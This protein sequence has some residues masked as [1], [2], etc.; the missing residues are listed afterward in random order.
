MTTILMTLHTIKKKLN[1]HDELRCLILNA[2]GY[3]CGDGGFLNQGPFL[4]YVNKKF[5]SSNL[6]FT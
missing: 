2:Y 3:L 4:S 1:F 6:Y 5:I